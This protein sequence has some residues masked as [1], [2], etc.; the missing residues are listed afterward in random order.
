MNLSLTI[1]G[2]RREVELADA[3]RCSIARERLQLTGTRRAATAVNAAPAVLVNGQRIN[4]CLALR[5]A[6]MPR[7]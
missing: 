4:S 7:C 5:S 2:V 1:N 6:M 3:S